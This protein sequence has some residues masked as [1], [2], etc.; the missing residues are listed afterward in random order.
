MQHL[1]STAGIP[2]FL[3]ES[4]AG[5]HL[6]GPAFVN[7]TVTTP[8]PTGG[9][10]FMNFGFLSPKLTVLAAGVAALIRNPVTTR[11]RFMGVL[12]GD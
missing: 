11:R 9:T 7:E 10:M 4:N 12:R 2:V 8:P 5:Q 6:V 3:N 1:L